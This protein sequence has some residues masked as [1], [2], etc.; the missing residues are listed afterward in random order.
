MGWSFITVDADMAFLKAPEAAESKLD[1]EIF[2]DNNSLVAS[3]ASQVQ[4]G[5]A[6]S[7]QVI[8]STNA[9][10]F[11]KSVPF[12]VFGADWSVRVRSNQ[13]FEQTER[14]GGAY[15]VSAVGL[16]VTLLMAGLVW[17]LQTARERALRL[18]RAMTAE[19]Q[20]AKEEA[21]AANLAKSEFL[22]NMSHEIRTPMTAIMGF[23]DLLD[24]FGDRKSAPRQRLEYIATIRRNSEH[25]LAIINDILDLSRIEAG[26]LIAERIPTAPLQILHDTF[27]LMNVRAL[28]KSIELEGELKTP[29]PAMVYSD[30][31]RLRQILINLVGNAIK[32]TETGS[33]KL[34]VHYDADCS[35]MRFEVTDTGIGMT[36]Q[37]ME[38]LFQSFSQAD[39]GTTRKYGG[40]GLGLCISKRLANILGGDI[41]VR[42]MLGRGSVFSLTIRG[43]AVASHGEMIPAGKIGAEVEGPGTATDETVTPITPARPLEGIRI[44]LAEDGPDN[45][46]LLV[47]LLTTAGASVVAV[48]NG[49]L[50]VEKLSCDGDIDAPLIEP[51]PYD[52][53]LSDMQMP[54][55]DGYM[56]ARL[57]REKGCQIP[58]V[59][60]TANAMS[61]DDERCKAAGCDDYASKP[62][63]RAK[64]ISTIER[65]LAKLATVQ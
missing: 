20:V 44:L 15:L 42:S 2:T 60:L 4:Q 51:P 39:T 45:T 52:L 24:E 59:A 6:P 11:C 17:N 10:T 7:S 65:Q 25:L 61:G 63:S 22:A 47:H 23:A 28:T 1:V 43:D 46:R 27:S 50:A 32:F 9:P 58:I 64:L 14:S 5:M 35:E 3:V 62:I 21:E 49:R 12:R 31:I 57:L 29:I 53:I 55:M 8:R 37:Q 56:A 13:H 48:E 26:K 18:A 34:S 19:L 36:P 38:T 16:A 33:V 30:P 41:T 40:S 54:V